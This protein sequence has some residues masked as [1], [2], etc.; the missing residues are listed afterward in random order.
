MIGK[1]LEQKTENM[2]LLAK[3][4]KSKILNKVDQLSGDGPYGFLQVSGGMFICH[5]TEAD[6]EIK[7]DMNYLMSV[8]TQRGVFRLYTK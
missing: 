1:N 7:K 2:S 5:E 4:I 6:K 3:T 8:N